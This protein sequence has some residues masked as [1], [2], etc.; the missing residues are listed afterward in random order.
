MTENNYLQKT[1]QSYLLVQ[2]SSEMAPKF[3][4]HVPFLSES[5]NMVWNG[6]NTQYERVRIP[7][8]AGLLKLWIRIPPGAWM[9]VVIFVSF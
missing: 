2:L 7:A 3:A 5:Q 9:S 1:G 6:L 4:F 8:A